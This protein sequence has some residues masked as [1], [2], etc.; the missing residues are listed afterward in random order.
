MQET[1]PV[2]I[3]L[4]CPDCL[5]QFAAPADTP[6]D[7]VLDRM[8]DEGPWYALASG[9]TFEDMICSALLYRGAI[10]CPECAGPVL[11]RERTLGRVIDLLSGRDP[12]PELSPGRLRKCGPQREDA[13]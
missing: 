9:G 10:R 5:N 6:C 1:T 11:I 4:Y 3:E 13:L 7:E 8:R 2:E 12:V